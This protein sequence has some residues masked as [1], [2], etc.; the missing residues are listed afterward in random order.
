M[1]LPH[2]LLAA[3]Q[4]PP[5]QTEALHL[6]SASDWRVRYRGV[7]ML[8]SVAP[9]DLEPAVKRK[10]IGLL[11]AETDDLWGHLEGKLPQP[12]HPGLTREQYEEGAG[13]WK[14][15]YLSYLYGL[16]LGLQD[17]KT[18]PLLLYATSNPSDVDRELARYGRQ[19]IGAVVECLDRF[20]RLRVL[21]DGKPQPPYFSQMAMADILTDMMELNQRK[22]L[23]PPLAPSDYDS[24]RQALRP[25]M[26]S[27]DPNVR[28]Y[29]ARGLI[30]AGDHP[31]AAPIR[32]TLLGFLRSPVPG[33]RRAGLE[34]IGTNL[35]NA[36]YVP[37]AKV[38]ELASSDPYY[39][40]QGVLG[41]GPVVYPV[42][43]AAQKVLRKL[44]KGSGQTIPKK[45]PAPPGP[46]P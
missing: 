15:E 13:E 20:S 43:E 38:K 44:G 39:Y 35:D 9:R 27:S 8:Q 30:Q 22:E 11:Q 46:H 10:L 3:S 14:A 17:P 12:K 40:R 33:M 37:M 23:K 16:V 19:G 31:G 21:A 18:L 7:Q 24:I 28:L 36:N 1:L 4:A 5:N 29:A 32:D 34:W 41:K 25:L 26:T 6:L 45:S 2:A 42:R